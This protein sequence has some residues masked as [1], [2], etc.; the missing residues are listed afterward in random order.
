MAF[1]ERV[2]AKTWRGEYDREQY[3]QL[4]SF[5]GRRNLS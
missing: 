5:F 3:P 1:Y 4:T 2:Q